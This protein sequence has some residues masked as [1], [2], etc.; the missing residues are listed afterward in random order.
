MG[1]GSGTV[2]QVT[3][4]ASSSYQPNATNQQVIVIF[5]LVDE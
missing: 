3:D 5:K 4:N 1:F 2:L